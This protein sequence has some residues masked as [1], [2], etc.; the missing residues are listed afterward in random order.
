MFRIQVLHPVHLW[1]RSGRWH[2]RPR[3]SAQLL[4]DTSTVSRTGTSVSSGLRPFSA[5][6][7]ACVSIAY[8]R[9]LPIGAICVIGWAPAALALWLLFVLGVHVPSASELLYLL[10]G[11]PSA[12]FDSVLPDPGA[13]L[14]VLGAFVLA[15]VTGQALVSGAITH[16]LY[17]AAEGTPRSSL[18]SLR[19]SAARLH[20][21]LPALA[22]SVGLVAFPFLAGAAVAG[23]LLWSD[24][25]SWQQPVLAGAVC[26]AVLGLL[27]L[28]VWGRLALWP[29]AAVLAPRGT[30]S[31]AVSVRCTSRRWWQTVLRLLVV[32]L[33]V[34]AVTSAVS[35]PLIAI[36]ASGSAAVIAVAVTARIILSIVSSGVSQSAA[37]LVYCDT[38]A[39]AAP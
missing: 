28:A 7:S 5:Y 3:P 17:W 37:A 16:Q 6:L 20:R 12:T 38:S 26:T 15:Y 10:D 11:G 1:S 22:M 23:W 27:S 31:P 4:R 34:A 29:A 35:A 24:G 14:R 36:G 9:M 13:A 30:F 33:A 2:A 19:R 32:A 25:T 21:T 18:A 39:P 8:Q